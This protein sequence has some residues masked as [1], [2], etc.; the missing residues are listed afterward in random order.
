[1][2]KNEKLL[3]LTL[4]MKLG[5][6]AV[7]ADELLSPTGHEFDHV[8]LKGLLQDPEIVAWIKSMGPLLPV[9]RSKS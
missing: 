8:V 5:S 3:P 6:I 1:M 2:N 4:A 9:K 7:H